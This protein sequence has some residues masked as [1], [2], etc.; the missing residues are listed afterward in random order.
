M[1]PACGDVGLQPLLL[2]GFQVGGAAVADVGHPGT[3]RLTGV[4]HDPLQRGEQ[5]QRVADLVAYA[6]GHDHLLVPIDGGLAVVAVNP[7]ISSFEDVAAGGSE[8][9]PGI[10]FGLCRCI[11]E[12]LYV[13]HRLLIAFCDGGW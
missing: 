7:D 1:L 13:W 4:G 11:R 12:E 8:I 6:D 5:M 10:G 9:A 3:R 2:T